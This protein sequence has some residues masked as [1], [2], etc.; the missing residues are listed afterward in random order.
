VVLLWDTDGSSLVERPCWVG[1]WRCTRTR[2]GGPRFNNWPQGLTALDSALRSELRRL[3]CTPAYHG[4]CGAETPSSLARCFLTVPLVG[5]RMQEQDV[6]EF[7]TQPSHTVGSVQRDIACQRWCRMV[8]Q[9][10]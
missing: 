7:S 2:A 5:S 6:C 3:L 4:E 9:L 8:A 10:V 1:L